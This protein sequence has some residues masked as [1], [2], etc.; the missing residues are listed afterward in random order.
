MDTIH[1]WTKQRTGIVVVD[2]LQSTRRRH[3]QR[4]KRGEVNLAGELLSW[5]DL[6]MIVGNPACDFYLG[7]GGARSSLAFLNLNQI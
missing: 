7:G 5:L 1:A 2:F 4:D 6:L 3:Q